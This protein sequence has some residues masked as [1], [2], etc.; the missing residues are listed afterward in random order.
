M[1]RETTDVKIRASLQ[2]VTTREYPKVFG[3]VAWSE[4]C[5]WYSSLPLDAVL[6]LFFESV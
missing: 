3:L 4:K 2:T 1:V 6:S 5:K